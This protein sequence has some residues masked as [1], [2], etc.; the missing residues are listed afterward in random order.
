MK[1]K[2]CLSVQVIPLFFMAPLAIVYFQFFLYLLY[3]YLKPVAPAALPEIPDIEGAEAVLS[4]PYAI[5][6]DL[7]F[8]VWLTASVAWQA[9]QCCSKISLPAPESPSGTV[10]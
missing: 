5:I 6:I 1:A 10:T 7:F 3:L 2:R 9:E 8:I 4:S